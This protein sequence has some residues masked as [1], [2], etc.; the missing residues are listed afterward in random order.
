MLGLQE[1]EENRELPGSWPGSLASQTG[2]GGVG[3]SLI[4]PPEDQLNSGEA[5]GTDLRSPLQNPTQA[6]VGGSPSGEVAA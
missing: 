3:E 1:G 6:G 2:G 4:K 5:Q